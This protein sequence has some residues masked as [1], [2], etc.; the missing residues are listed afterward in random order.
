ML[1]A[2]NKRTVI[3]EG[4][5]EM[6]HATQEKALHAFTL[7]GTKGLRELGVEVREAR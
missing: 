3:K 1:P 4:V 6:D 7:L 5:L 2:K